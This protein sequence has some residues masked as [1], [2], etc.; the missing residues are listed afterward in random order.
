MLRA[1]AAKLGLDAVGI[2]RLTGSDELTSRLAHFLNEN[3]HGDMDWME[4]NADRRSDPLRLWPEAK[5]AVVFGQSYAPPS[6][7][8]DALEQRS[9]DSGIPE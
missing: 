5:S 8:L 4:T 3:R 1:E 9:N 6:N 7:P 2:T